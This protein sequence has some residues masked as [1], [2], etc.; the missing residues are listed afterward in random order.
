MN[1]SSSSATGNKRSREDEAE[2]GGGSSAEAVTCSKC[3]LVSSTALRCREADCNEARCAGCL[4][5][6]FKTCIDC[7]CGICIEHAVA[8]VSCR[9]WFCL[10]CDDCEVCDV[11]YQPLCESCVTEGKTCLCGSADMPI[12]IN[13]DDDADDADDEADEEGAGTGADESD[14]ADEV[15]ASDDSEEGGEEADCSCVYCGLAHPDNP[16]S[17]DG[18]G[19][20][21]D[22]FGWE[23]NMN[24]AAEG[25]CPDCADK[26]MDLHGET[27]SWVDYDGPADGSYFDDGA[28]G[29]SAM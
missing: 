3:S 27:S 19:E 28:Q 17:A 21:P 1:M 16:V 23:V 6:D 10:G 9:D 8:C 24:N 20:E 25:L 29:H 11:C 13:S 15:D 26:L 7:G 22:S 4:D 18:Y 12:E 14:A 5:S 2:D